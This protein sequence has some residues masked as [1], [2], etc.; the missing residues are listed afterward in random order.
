MFSEGLLRTCMCTY[1]GA[2]SLYVK[3]VV[4]DLK[5]C[6]FKNGWIRGC[7]SSWH[8]EA[9]VQRSTILARAGE[10]LQ[11][12]KEKEPGLAKAQ[13]MDGPVTPQGQRLGFPARSLAIVW[14]I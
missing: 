14:L 10:I 11:S 3:C 1:K 9:K 13:S 4:L 2:F 8:I 6:V 7:F 12:L 5:A